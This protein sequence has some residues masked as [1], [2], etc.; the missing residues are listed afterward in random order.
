MFVRIRLLRELSITGAPRALLGGIT[1]DC[2]RPGWGHPRRRRRTRWRHPCNRAP[3]VPEAARFK[4]V[5]TLGSRE[6][7]ICLRSFASASGCDWRLFVFE[8][9]DKEPFH[10]R[11]S[12]AAMATASPRTRVQCW[13]AARRTDGGGSVS[14]VRAEAA[15]PTALTDSKLR[16]SNTFG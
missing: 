12:V 4:R 1:I 6:T 7:R 5:A 13:A 9:E 16:W 11:E 3:P 8:F 2:E 14:I 10:P 15:Q